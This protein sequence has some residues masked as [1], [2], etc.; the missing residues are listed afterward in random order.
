[1]L[2]GSS[3]LMRSES[4]SDGGW[5]TASDHPFPWLVLNA[6]GSWELHAAH[7]EIRRLSR[8]DL[9]PSRPI[10]G[11]Y[12]ARRE[13]G[14][15]LV[16]TSES[17]GL[18]IK[19]E[20][21]FDDQLGQWLTLRRTARVAIHLPESDVE[22][23][24][25]SKLWATVLQALRSAFLWSLGADGQWHKLGRFRRSRDL[26]IPA[27]GELVLTSDPIAPIAIRSNGDVFVE[28]RRFRDGQPIE[29]EHELSRWFLYRR[30]GLLQKLYLLSY[31]SN[32]TIT[33][34]RV[35]TYQYNTWWV[36][37]PVGENTAFQR[38]MPSKAIELAGRKFIWH[39]KRA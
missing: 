6:D 13:A 8:N 15:N 11:S 19:L 29:F 32:R 39:S 7:G 4:A 12:W 24:P 16:I 27:S 31:D 9:L 26:P 34:V 22:K 3:I 38:T 21:R 35:L 1:M 37:E 14:K 5:A 20:F 10:V 17:D 30:R 23:T 36:W 33:S 28:T 2:G 18:Q 25:L